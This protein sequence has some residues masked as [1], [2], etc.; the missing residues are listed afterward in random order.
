M[1]SA[2]AS[3]V[4]PSLQQG[5]RGSATATGLE[6][7][8]HEIVLAGLDT[9]EIQTFDDENLR[10]GV[11]SA[12]LAARDHAGGTAILPAAALLALAFAGSLFSVGWE[13]VPAQ[14][15]RRQE[16]RANDD[17]DQ[18]RQYLPCLLRYHSMSDDEATE[19]DKGKPAN[20]L[21]EIRHRCSRV[22][23]AAMTSTVFLP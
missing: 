21:H 3:V 22:G 12:S 20:L 13:R 4:A 14:D 15:L 19:Q 8:A 5:S 1:G 16:S 18:P 9:R 11:R 2:T 23:S 17:E 7:Q 6:W 10:T